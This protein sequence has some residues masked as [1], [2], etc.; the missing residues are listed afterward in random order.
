MMVGI[1]AGTMVVGRNS[2][3]LARMRRA[4]TGGARAAVLTI[5]AAMALAGGR[6]AD[7]DGAVVGW[8]YNK[9]GQ[10]ST[11]AALPSVTQIAGGGFHT[12]AFACTTP[13]H[14]RNSGNLG[15]I[16]SGSP[17]EFTFDSLPPAASSVALTIRAR[18][19]LNLATEFLSVRLDG[20]AFANIF[21]D[22][23]NDCPAALD[24][25]VLTITAKQFNA[26][27]SDS[28]LTVRLDAPSGVNAAQCGDGACEIAVFYE[29]VPV[30]CND[31]GIED[32]CEATNPA[33]DCN[34]NGVPDSCDIA[35]GFSIDIN[36][37]AR[38]DEC[39]FDCNNNALPDTYELAQGLA[40]DCNNNAGIDSCDISSG[41]ALDCN[42]NAIPD[43]CD[44]A[45][46]TS[47]DI[48][49]NGIPDSCQV[50]CN[51]NGQPDT[52]E[53]ANDPSR[54]CNNNAALDT[55]EISANPALDCNNN[56]ALDSCELLAN[57]SLDCNLN[58]ALDACDIA[59]G[60]QDKDGDNRI[61]ACEIALGDFDLDGA[62]TAA[63]LAELLSLW[64]FVNQPYGDLNGDGVISAAD[65]AMLLDRWG[66][67]Y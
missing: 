28:S 30:D 2:S 62:I 52:Y 43:S 49:S 16:G 33:F 10:C 22:T 58:G 50:D 6:A 37:N 18:A 36:A 59:K 3:V 65:L 40:L 64:G 53:I 5:G 25:V 34:D 12:I 45:S 26:L 21:V 14:S 1:N 17:R 24:E 48:D 20:A 46:G 32:S 19:D 7:A 11:P 47:N 42:V 55:C 27:I 23:G 67:L 57:P 15:T 44:I 63:D 9:Y 31:N 51:G 38:P 56:N 13:T 39:E 29:S 60:A 4:R 66:P 8:G 41:V 35:G 61:D 54:D